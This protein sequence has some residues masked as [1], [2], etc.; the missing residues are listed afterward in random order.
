MCVQENVRVTLL[1]TQ[2]SA[3][4]AK[5]CSVFQ[6]LGRARVPNPAWQRSVAGLDLPSP[7]LD[8][9]AAALS[10]QYDIQAARSD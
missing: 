8:T 6:C 3:P 4:G 2:L 9:D 10:R 5:L 7:L 1:L